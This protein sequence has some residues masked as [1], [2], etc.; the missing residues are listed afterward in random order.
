MI[1]GSHNRNFSSSSPL[2]EIQGRITDL[3]IS[4]KTPTAKERKTPNNTNRTENFIS[5]LKSPSN[6]GAHNKSK[7]RLKQREVTPSRNPNYCGAVGGGDRFIPNRS[8]T[9][10]DF[11]NHCLSQCES[12]LLNTSNSAPT[13]PV[14]AEKEI[15]IQ[16]MRA[17]SGNDLNC[18]E[19]ILMYKKGQAPVAPLGYA[20]HSKVLYC[21]S[22]SAANSVRKGLRHIPTTPERVLDAPN[23]MDD[24]YL[25]LM[26]WGQNNIIAIALTGTLYLWNAE[27]GDIATLFDIPDSER[28]Y[29]SSVQ[30]TADAAY[31]AVGL[32]NGEIK[33]FD[34]TRETP[35]RKMQVQINRVGSLAWRQHLVSAGCRSG[36]IYH[37]DVR[38]AKH[39]VGTFEKHSQEVCGLRWSHDLRYLAS[40]GGDNIANIWEPQMISSQEAVP[41]YSLDDHLATVK[42]IA[43]NP[44]KSHS[45]ATGGGINDRS[46]K[47]WN[48]ATG[49]LCRSEQTD[50][51]VAI[52]TTC[53]Y[54]LVNGIIFSK[55]YDEIISA[56]GYPS[57]VLRIWK[58][59]SMSC[60]QELTGHTDRV[61]GIT[62]SPDGQL[63][64]SASADESM[65]LW[66]CFKVDKNSSNKDRIKSSRLFATVR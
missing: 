48:L 44:H 63:V 21:S 36:R 28:L 25:N 64:M 16:L 14:K 41:L 34:P 45:L 6:N 2:R 32:S 19:R 57:N 26:D 10:F 61:L 17:K 66:A 11:A 18:D 27:T 3:N 22:V 4:S 7:S 15:K 62:M 24:V 55:T 29:I 58:N 42:A 56:H 23:L 59:S 51:Q 33:L 53:I 31:L 50:S 35:L 20:H 9:H 54:I 43:F 47:T 30:W 39:H 38:V 65:R 8:A 46:I 60:I 40:G 5:R 52:A 37:H 1:S 12:S 13:S 49:T